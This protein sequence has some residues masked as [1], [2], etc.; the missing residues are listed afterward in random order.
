M[1][2]PQRFCRTKKKETMKHVSY[3]SMITT[4]DKVES[5]IGT[6]EFTDG[7]PIQKT[8]HTVVLEV[9]VDMVYTFGFLDVTQGP[10]VLEVPPQLVGLI[11]DAWFGWVARVGAASSRARFD[12]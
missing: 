5:R 4:P 2:S 9:N 3:P 12:S 10:L 11:N 7:M 8:L 1:V 6:L